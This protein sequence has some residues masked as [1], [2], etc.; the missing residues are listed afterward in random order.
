MEKPM[1]YKVDRYLTGPSM[2]IQQDSM[3]YQGKRRFQQ[4]ISNHN[5]K[6]R[7]ILK[8]VLRNQIRKIVSA[9]ELTEERFFI[10]KKR[11]KVLCVCVF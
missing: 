1:E 5:L 7:L 11:T 8:R 2:P 6:R 9:L 10:C 4:F 3:R